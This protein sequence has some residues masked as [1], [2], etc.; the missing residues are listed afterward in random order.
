M[1]SKERLRITVFL[2][3]Q[4]DDHDVYDEVQYVRFEAKEKQLNQLFA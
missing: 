4:I 2:H 3:G 1:N